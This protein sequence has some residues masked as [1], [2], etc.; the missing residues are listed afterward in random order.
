MKDSRTQ[1]Q[2]S[3]QTQR[4]ATPSHA[5][6]YYYRKFPPLVH[7]VLWQNLLL[8]SKKHRSIAKKNRYYLNN[9]SSLNSTTLTISIEQFLS[10]LRP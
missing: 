6:I 7:V 9:K 4:F 5:P 2:R 3:T 10:D 8:L 1:N